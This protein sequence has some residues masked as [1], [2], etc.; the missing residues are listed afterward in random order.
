VSDLGFKQLTVENWLEKDRVNSYFVKLSLVDGHIRPIDGDDRVR[1]LL[2]HSLKA[3]VPVEVRR[4]FEVARGALAYGF[5]FYPLY[6]L[7]SEQLFRV[8]EAA[9]TQKCRA[10]GIKLKKN[11]FEQKIEHLYAAGMISNQERD[12]WHSIRKT[13]NLV[14]HPRFQN[15]IAPASALDLLEHIAARVNTLFS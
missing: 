1:A 4:L 13:R 7:A 10:I 11:N 12:S 8:A 6:T 9:V 2:A 3:S 5:Y 14:S 15:I